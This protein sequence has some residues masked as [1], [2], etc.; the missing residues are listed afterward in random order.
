MTEQRRG[1][2][3]PSLG[4]GSYCLTKGTPDFTSSGQVAS[5][6]K[7]CGWKGINWTWCVQ[8]EEAL[9]THTRGMHG[10]VRK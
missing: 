1:T 8:P 4:A 3:G 2:A 7:G 5:L 10:K 6:K 9:E